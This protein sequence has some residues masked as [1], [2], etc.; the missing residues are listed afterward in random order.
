MYELKAPK[1]KIGSTFNSWGGFSV[2]LLKEDQLTKLEKTKEGK[3]QFNPQAVGT[4][5][6]PTAQLK[7]GGDNLKFPKYGTAEGNAEVKSGEKLVNSAWATLD[8]GNFTF[9]VDMSK[10][11]CDDS[12]VEVM[13]FA[14]TNEITG[15]K[16]LKSGSKASSQYIGKNNY[17]HFRS[18]GWVVNTAKEYLMKSK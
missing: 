16:W 13:V 14:D 15:D 12:A 8:E 2:L 6:N 3:E 1:D 4:F 5:D 7:V 10:I 9:Y 17:A 18:D 11:L